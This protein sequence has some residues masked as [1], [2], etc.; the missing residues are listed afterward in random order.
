MRWAIAHFIDRVLPYQFLTNQLNDC[1]VKDGQ[2][3][4]PTCTEAI[5]ERIRTGRV[6]L[7]GVA[8]RIAKY[9][10]ASNWKVT[11][12]EM[13]WAV[14]QE[15]LT[16]LNS[17]V[18]HFAKRGEL[19]GTYHKLLRKGADMLR[20]GRKWIGLAVL[21]VGLSHVIVHHAL[22]AYKAYQI[23]VTA[24]NNALKVNTR[25]ITTWVDSLHLGSDGKWYG[26]HVEENCCNRCDQVVGNRHNPAHGHTLTIS[27]MWREE[28]HKY[29]KYVRTCSV[30]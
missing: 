17:Q 16:T 6:T 1:S 7:Y 14:R 25:V 3:Q 24:Q 2:F 20:K 19:E 10:A 29:S 21:V 23:D 28:P 12:P 26:G 15:L 13:Y 18:G 4:C 9:E 5:V 27:G 22:P 30:R 8:H 11:Y